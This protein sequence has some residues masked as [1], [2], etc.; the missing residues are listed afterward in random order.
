LP[1]SRHSCLP[2]LRA[3]VSLFRPHCLFPNTIYDSTNFLDY[4]ILPQLFADCL[5]DDA[6]RAILT[7]AKLYAFE[8]SRRRGRDPPEQA[9]TATFDNMR[10]TIQ[11]RYTESIAQ[12]GLL[13]FAGPDHFEAEIR[14]IIEGPMP[15]SNMALQTVH[16]EPEG[17]AEVPTPIIKQ[18]PLLPDIP[19]PSRQ[20][21]R[22]SF[23]PQTAS[24]VTPPFN[25]WKY[26][27]VMKRRLEERGLGPVG[28][29]KR[30][31]GL[32]MHTLHVRG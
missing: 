8:E 23:P 27:R 6:K 30:R 31:E 9:Y 21:S 26:F 13:N 5:S 4:F 12:A 2:E 32:G 15:T 24:V 1:L 25:D 3:L 19:C 18:S 16:E 14:R 17:E 10:E 7:R 29:K 20:S 11:L 28:S 22:S